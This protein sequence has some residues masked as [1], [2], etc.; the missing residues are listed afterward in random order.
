MNKTVVHNPLHPPLLSATE[1]TKIALVA[2]LYVAVTALLA[3]ISFGAI[4][5]RLSEMFNY[6]AL[7]NK[8]YVIAVTMGV[9]IVNFMSP[10]WVLDVPIGGTATLLVLLLCRLLTKRIKN[11]V[12]KIAITALVFAFSMFTVAAQLVILFDL[13]FFYTWMTTA[14]GELLSM[15]IGGIVIYFLSKKIDLTK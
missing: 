9:L 10:T 13:P 5:L 4:Q 7:Y 15:S 14:A 3:V 6:L 2:S 1:M 8:R 12:V 11:D